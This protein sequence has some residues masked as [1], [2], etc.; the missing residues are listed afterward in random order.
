MGDHKGITVVL[1][2]G[3]ESTRSRLRSALDAVVDVVGD[4]P[5]VERALQAVDL[6]VPDVVVFDGGEGLAHFGGTTYLSTKGDDRIWACDGSAGPDADGLTAGEPAP[7]CSPSLACAPGSSCVLS[8]GSTG[9][10]VAEGEGNPCGFAQIGEPVPGEEAL[11]ADD[12]IAITKRCQSREEGL[13]PA[14]EIAV[15]ERLALSI[16][17]A[18]VHRPRVEIDAAAQLVSPGVQSHAVPPLEGLFDILK[19]TA[20]VA[21]E[22]ACMS[23]NS[24]ERTTG[25]RPVA[26]QLMIR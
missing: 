8:R 25:L 22:E 18:D 23:F 13:G 21:P 10:C 19:A 5:S 3:D 7:L 15:Q 14:G 9:H 24:F 17:D 2:L 11:A 26:A 1:G 16:E 6:H 4:E 20:W 12:E